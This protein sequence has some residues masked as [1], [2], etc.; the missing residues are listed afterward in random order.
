MKPQ[1]VDQ[2]TTYALLIGID[3]ADKTHALC[4]LDPHT[5]HRTHQPLE[6]D[7]NLLHA[8]LSDLKT[9]YKGQSIA[10]S[11]DQGKGAVINILL[12]Y[13]FIDIYPVPT[14]TIGRYRKT[15]RSSGAKDDPTDAAFLLDLLVLHR[16]KLRRLHPNDAL[17]RRLDALVRQRRDTV[18]HRTRCNNQLKALLKNYFPLFLNVCG[19]DLFAPMACRLLLNYSCF[20]D[21]QTAAPDEV[22]RFYR[23]QGCWSPQ[24][25][26]KRLHIIRHALPLTT[27]AALI[28]PSITHARFLATILLTVDAAIKDYDNHIKTLFEQH[29]D[30]AIF[31]SFPGAGPTFAP[32]LLTA[33]GSDRACFPEAANIAAQSGIAPVHHESGNTMV[34]FWRKGCPKFLR[35]SFQEYASESIRHSLWARAYYQMQRHRGKKHHMAVRALAFKWIRIMFRCWKNRQPYNELHYL[36]ALQRRHSPLLEYLSKS[37]QVFGTAACG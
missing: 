29:Q 22:S 21:L 27:D 6:H 18:A 32:R 24:V 26:Q 10:V 19:E 14:T 33:F 20:E 25:I 2:K 37:D 4:V 1:H 34:V 12:E 31:K 7:P 3:W 13:D 15:F 36:Q 17:T 5:G 35:Q 28:E 8:W 30:A 23:S 16:D 11:I 9:R